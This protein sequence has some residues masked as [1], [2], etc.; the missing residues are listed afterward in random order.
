MLSVCIISF[1]TMRN[2]TSSLNCSIYLV[3]VSPSCL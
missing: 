2:E 1:M 3:Q